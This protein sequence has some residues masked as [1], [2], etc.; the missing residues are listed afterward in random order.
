MLGE[1]R[2]WDGFG[3]LS[4]RP[5]FPPNTKPGCCWSWGRGEAGGPYIH[6][7]VGGKE[8]AQDLG[9]RGHALVPTWHE[10]IVIRRS[11][12]WEGVAPPPPPLLDPEGSR[13]L[14]MGLGLTKR[15]LSGEVS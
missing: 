13:G 4:G 6:G 14:G 11:S 7:S 12:R 1:A 3:A 2:V 9:T 8:Q 15:A 10:L 5:L